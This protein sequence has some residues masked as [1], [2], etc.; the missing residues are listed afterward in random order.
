MN[1]KVKRNLILA[2]PAA[3]VVALAA[4]DRPAQTTPGRSSAHTASSPRQTG[5]GLKPLALGERIK[6]SLRVDPNVSAFTIEVDTAADAVTLRGE[7][8]T[9]EQRQ[10]AGRVASNAA[11]GVPVKNELV[12]KDALAGATRSDSGRRLQQGDAR[13]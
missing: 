4:C 3:L 10:W 2:I 12:V 5:A 7:V 11:G 6:E 8:Q 1:T 9:A 13:Q